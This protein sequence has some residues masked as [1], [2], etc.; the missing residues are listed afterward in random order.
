MATVDFGCGGN[1]R[2][3]IGVDI[4]PWPG[5]DHVVQLGFERVPIEDNSMEKAYCVH[6]IE[7]IPFMIFHQ[8]SIGKWKRYF[9]MFQFL[10]EVHRVLKPGAEFDVITLCTDQGNGTT[11]HRIFQDPTHCSVWTLDTIRH[12]VA[13]RGDRVGDA[14]DAMAGLKTPFSLVCLERNSDNLLHFVLRK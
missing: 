8:D 2:G 5:V 12:F 7:H 9:P 3:D 6:A 10:M 11:D 4:C 1:K 14:N 13:A